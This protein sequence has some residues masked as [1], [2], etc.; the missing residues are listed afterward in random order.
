MACAVWYRKCP[1]IF[2]VPSVS[3]LTWA[4][5]C[6][7]LA[8][9]QSWCTGRTHDNI[10]MATF[11]CGIMVNDKVYMAAG[12]AQDGISSVAIPLSRSEAAKRHRAIAHR[13]TLDMWNMPAFSSA[14]LHVYEP[15]QRNSCSW[16]SHPNG[17]LRPRFYTLSQSMS[18]SPLL[19]VYYFTIEMADRPLCQ[20]C[21]C[22]ET[23][24]HLLC[25]CA[26]KARL[27][28]WITA[29]LPKRFWDWRSALKRS[30][31]Q[32]NAAISS[33]NRNLR[34]VVTVPWQVAVMLMCP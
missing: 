16:T 29:S 34:P 10:S 4:A 26:S 9:A 7:D 32:G 27:V 2:T 12:S 17:I 20:Y 3:R 6:G 8:N 22:R 5:F 11:H 25:E 31:C 33:R 18:W 14:Q 23:I 21:G 15:S 19:I 24:A 1:S 28:C 13:L 30:G